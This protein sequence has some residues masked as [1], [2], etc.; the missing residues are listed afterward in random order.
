MKVALLKSKADLDKLRSM[1]V[2]DKLRSKKA[3]LQTLMSLNNLEDD[4]YDSDL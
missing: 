3:G 2:L 1:A 4:L